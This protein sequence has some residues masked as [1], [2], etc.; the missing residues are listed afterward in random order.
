MKV[1]SGNTGENTNFR[2]EGG[3]R[4][5]SEFYPSGS[6]QITPGG[7]D[8]NSQTTQSQL[9]DKKKRSSHTDA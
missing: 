2:S 6:V 1:G 3:L 7:I 9:H 5:K 4:M 8:L